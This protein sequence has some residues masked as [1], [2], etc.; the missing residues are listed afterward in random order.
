M[1]ER[2]VRFLRD[3]RSRPFFLYFAST[4]PHLALQAPEMAVARYK[5]K[6]PDPPYTGTNRYLPHFKPRAAYA[7]MISRLDEHVGQL[8]Q[9]ADELGLAKNTIFIFTSD[10]GPLY[11]RLGGTDCEFFESAAQWRGRKG[12]LYEG[13]VRVPL[14]VRWQGRIMPGS[15]SDRVTGFEDWLPTLVE[16]SGARHGGERVDGISFAATLFGKEQQPRRFLY[17]EFPAYGGQQSVRVGDWKAIRQNLTNTVA[18]IRTELYNLKMDPAESR[19]VAAENAD[20]VARLE[21]L[22]KNQ[23]EPSTLFRL[24]AIDRSRP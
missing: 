1:A 4:I 2:A 15:T 21:A 9:T 13:G 12:S 23:H 8:M 16:L 24:P 7:A 10:N 5:G 19:D 11:G 3:N 6:W 18:A 17:R 22:M 14:V 20:V